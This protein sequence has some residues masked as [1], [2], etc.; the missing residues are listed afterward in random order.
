[1]ISGVTI[2][3]GDDAETLRMNTR[4]MMAIEQHFDKGLIEVL[5][6]LQKGFKISHL[7]RLISEC[8]D[9]GRGVD[10]DRAAEILD[11]IGVTRAG[12]VLGEVAEA[13]FP[14]AQAA[15]KNVKRAARSK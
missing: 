12:E 13:A 2:Q 3:V 9:D 6:G 8:A 1:M 5:Q 14:E 10:M 15:A 4:A 7:A 11:T